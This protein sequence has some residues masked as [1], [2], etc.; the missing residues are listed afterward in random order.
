MAFFCLGADQYDL[1]REDL[2]AESIRRIEHRRSDEQAIISARVTVERA[3]RE[4]MASIL[5]R[6]DA[7]NAHELTEEE[8]R[9]FAQ[10]YGHECDISP[11]EAL[12]RRLR[13]HS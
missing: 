4:R 6:I 10:L 11:R 7:G 9:A 2:L 3:D 12:S 13:D 5:N 8:L 1:P